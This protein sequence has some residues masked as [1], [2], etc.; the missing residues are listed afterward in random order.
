MRFTL[1]RAAVPLLVL[2]AFV[3]TF[4]SVTTDDD[5]VRGAA[6][7]IAASAAVLYTSNDQ[8]LWMALGE[9]T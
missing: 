3:I 5:R 6:A 2:A 9:V 8:N 1:D 7:A 4:W